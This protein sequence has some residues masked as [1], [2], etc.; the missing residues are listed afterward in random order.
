M[1]GLLFNLSLGELVAIGVVA[2]LVFGSKLPEVAAQL[3]VQVQRARRTLQDLRRET[4][5]D[6]EMWEVRRRFDEAMPRDV[7]SPVTAFQQ[8]RLEARRKLEERRAEDPRGEKATGAAPVDPKPV[9]PKPVDPEPA[10][11]QP[12]VAKPVPRESSERPGNAPEAPSAGS[13][14]DA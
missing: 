11:I 2:L 9:D 13:A 6:R 12:G 14:G 7:E 1:L 3:A 10:D 5:I 4:G 8:A